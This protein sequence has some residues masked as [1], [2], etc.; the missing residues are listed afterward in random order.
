MECGWRD[1]VREL[2][3]K[4]IKERG[5]NQV[6]VDDILEEVTPKGRALVPDTV[7]KELLLKLKTHLYNKSQQ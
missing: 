2:C 5:V 4:V 6:S 1:Q 7:K 3:R